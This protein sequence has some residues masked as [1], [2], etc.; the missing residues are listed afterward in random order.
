[1]NTTVPQYKLF[2]YECAV[3]C[4]KRGNIGSVWKCLEESVAIEKQ[5]ADGK[6][7]GGACVGLL[8]KGEE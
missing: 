7:G 3:H 1:M 6:Y 8:I 2:H 4:I 5:I